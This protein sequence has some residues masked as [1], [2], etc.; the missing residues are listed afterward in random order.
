MNGLG[1]TVFV[2]IFFGGRIRIWHKK[3][4]PKLDVVYRYCL[5]LPINPSIWFYIQVIK[6][7]LCIGNWRKSFKCQCSH[8][9]V[10]VCYNPTQSVK[11]KNKCRYRYS[12]HITAY[13]VLMTTGVRNELFV[14]KVMNKIPYMAPCSGQSQWA[15]D[16]VE[17]RVEW[18][19][20]SH[21]LSHMISY[22]STNEGGL[23][24]RLRKGWCTDSSDRPRQA[25]SLWTKVRGLIV[26]YSEVDR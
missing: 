18:T 2:S 8:Y 14:K 21:H 5:L 6:I 3:N 16:F 20:L 17:E 7:V 9:S 11:N 12:G 24:D 22:P 10:F 1:P 26:S 13:F 19:D 25:F 15:W 23:I 4:L